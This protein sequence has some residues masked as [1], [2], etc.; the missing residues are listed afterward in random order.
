MVACRFG[1]GSVFVCVYL[2][3]CLGSR[4]LAGY[5]QIPFPD[6]S[7]ESL[8]ASF[9]FHGHVLIA[10]AAIG[11]P[12]AIWRGYALQQQSEAASEQ[13]STAQS[14]LLNERYQKGVEMLG[15][16]DLSVRLGGVYA[17]DRL[18]ENE[19]STYHIR[20]MS[21][22]SAFVCNWHIKDGSEGKQN[23][24][25]PDNKRG[26]PPEDVRTVLEVVASRSG[27]Q[28][29]IESERKHSVDFA[30]AH[31]HRWVCSMPGSAAPLDFSNVNFWR[32]DLSQAY[33]RRAKFSDSNFIHANLSDAELMY[34][35]F[36]DAWLEFADLSGAL[37]SW[38]NLAGASLEGAKLSGT[39]LIGVKGLTQG[40]L[41]SAEIDLQRPPL[42][43][44][45]MDPIT[46]EPL[47]VPGQKPAP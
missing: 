13:S 28:R 35:D 10:I 7:P 40:Q 32:A 3:H 39:N 6:G 9:G 8:F 36:S 38:A 29:E 17:L 34:A 19:L 43:A 2:G 23:N 27:K 5:F 31:L 44:D 15:S 25:T 45:A 26:E 33:C 24:G 41:N 12:I 14:N 42:L 18:A 4:W 30:H 11:L 47:V 37:M 21:V 46:E 16:T 20:I 22:F 1:G